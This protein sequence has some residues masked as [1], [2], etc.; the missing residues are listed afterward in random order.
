MAINVTSVPTAARS[1]AVLLGLVRFADCALIVL[2][3][4][5]SYWSH[6]GVLELPGRYLLAVVIC[7]L[8]AFQVFHLVGLYKFS[9]LHRLPT[10]IGK[11][12]TGWLIV[13]LSLIALIFFTKTADDFSRLWAAIWLASAFVCFVLLRIILLLRLRSWRRQGKLVRNIAIIGAG[14]YGSRLLE[15]LKANMHDSSLNIVGV[16]DDRDTRVPRQELDGWPI[17]GNTDDLVERCRR[18]EIDLVIIALPWSAETRLVAIMNKIRQVPVDLQL[19]PE[20]VGFHLFD[21]QFTNLAGLPMLTVFER[22]LSGWKFLVK[23]FEDRLLSLI[24]LILI[25][26]L[27]A[28]I[29][30]AIK[31][32]SPGPVLFRQKRFGFNNNVITVWKFRTMYHRVGNSAVQHGGAIDDAV[33]GA[34]DGAVNEAVDEAVAQASRG[35]ARV[36]RLGRFLRRSSLDELPQFF[37]VLQGAMS[38]VGPRPHAV[39]HNTEFAQSVT[40]YYARHRVKPGITGWAQI[41]GYRGQTDT[42]E[43]LENRVKYDLYY[44]DNWSLLLDLKIILA[45]IFVGFF[46]ENAY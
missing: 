41:H 22:P 31:I 8:I 13:G 12:A 19:A 35:D 6:H 5:I 21:R 34:V 18:D 29:A 11:L 44:I 16:F 25:W 42:K 14:E 9:I 39:A 26:P 46:N 33:D 7:V 28:F 1:P 37:N 30:I 20:R 24:I 10:Q 3:A 36:T 2:T 32:D 43:K 45:T 27:L 23:T 38:I 15:H 4:V 17:L 40:A